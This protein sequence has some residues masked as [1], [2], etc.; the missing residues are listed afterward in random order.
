MATS[1]HTM[2]RLC[3]HGGRET[4]GENYWE[5]YAQVINWASVRILLS[6]AKIHNLPSKGIDF[7]LAFLQ[8]DLGVTVYM[9]L[10][11]GLVKKQRAC[12]E[13]MFYI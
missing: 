6:V 3:A 10:H 13:H 9:E 1:T 5:T 11:V 2:G 8:V 7:V 4:W 12:T